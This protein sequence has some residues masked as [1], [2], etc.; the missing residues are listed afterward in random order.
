MHKKSDL[1][2]NAIITF[3]LMSQTMI[4]RIIVVVVFSTT[5]EG[6]FTFVNRSAYVAE[7]RANSLFYYL[8]WDGKL[9][10]RIATKPLNISVWVVGLRRSKPNYAEIP[11]QC[12][13]LRMEALEGRNVI[14][15]ITSSHILPSK[16]STHQTDKITVTYINN[17]TCI[18]IQFS[19]LSS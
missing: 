10:V 8:E 5:Q 12:G 16:T 18:C 13:S 2:L 17:P 15:P 3:C 4:L 19:V 11:D 1:S 14:Y 6:P 7:P 9:K